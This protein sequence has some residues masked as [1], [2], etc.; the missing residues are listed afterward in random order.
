MPNEKSETRY[1]QLA[2]R[3][4]G[5]GGW[6]MIFVTDWTDFISKSKDGRLTGLTTGS[7]KPKKTQ[8]NEN[9][10]SFFGSPT[11]PGEESSTGTSSSS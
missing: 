9:Q 7:S 10:L 6:K 8:E 2:W 1:E 5:M 4:N 3:P 11:S